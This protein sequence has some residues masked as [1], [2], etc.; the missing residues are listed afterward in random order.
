MS[1]SGVTIFYCWAGRGIEADARFGLLSASKET[2]AC[3]IKRPLSD[4]LGTLETNQPMPFSEA[5]L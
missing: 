3:V 5:A 4:N 2:L 1:T